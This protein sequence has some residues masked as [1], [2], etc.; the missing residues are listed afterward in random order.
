[1]WSCA[2]RLSMHKNA[3]STR[4]QSSLIHVHMHV[5]YVKS[6]TARCENKWR[7][8]TGPPHHS[9]LPQRP[10]ARPAPPKPRTRPGHRPYI[11]LWPASNTPRTTAQHSTAHKRDGQMAKPQHTPHC[12]HGHATRTNMTP[13]SAHTHVQSQTRTCAGERKRPHH[14]PNH[15]LPHAQCCVFFT[16]TGPASS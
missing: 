4:P 7:R 16:H 11:T 10:H 12:H 2:L 14:T 9:T 8:S 6:K 5:L 13:H 1:M 3:T 15:P